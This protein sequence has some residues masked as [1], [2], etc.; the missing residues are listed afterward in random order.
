[1]TIF[2]RRNATWYTVKHWVQH[3]YSSYSDQ[4]FDTLTATEKETVDGVNYVLQNTEQVQGRVGALTNAKVRTDGIYRYV[5]PVSF[6]QKEIAEKDTV[7]EIFYK[8]PAV[9]TVIFYTNYTYIPRQQVKSEEN[10]DFSI[11]TSIPQRTGYKFGGWQYLKDS[12]VANA[13]GSYNDTDYIAVEELSDGSYSLQLSRTVVENAKL[14]D[15]GGT[16]ALY[17]Y[18]KWVSDTTQVRVILWTED[19]TGTDDVQAIAE[20]GNPEFYNQKYAG[21]SAEPVTHKPQHDTSDAYYSNAGSF[22][23]ENLISDSS[24]L[25]SDGTLL[26]GIKTRVDTEFK[27]RMGDV[28]GV[29][30]ADFYEL[31][32]FEIVH[33]EEDSITW[34]ATTASGDGKTTIY[35][36]FTRNIYTLKFHFYGEQGGSAYSVATKTNGYSYGNIE[37]FLNGEEFI[38]D[39]STSSSF[40]SNSFGKTTATNDS[41]M[42]V[43]KMITVKA[44]YGADLRDVWPGARPDEEINLSDGTLAKLA[45]WTA[46]MGKYRDDANNTASAHYHEATIMGVYASMGSEIVAAPANPETIHHLVAFWAARSDG[47]ISYYRYN[48]CYEVPDLNVDGMTKVSIY[49]NDTQNES[50]FLYLVP[51]DN[52]N[53]AKYSFNDLMRVSY[54]ASGTLTYNDENG[55]YYAVRGYND[56]YYALARQVIAPSTNS[57]GSQNPSARLHMTR[58]NP[59]ADHSTQYQD[60][61]GGWENRPWFSDRNNPYDLY[62]YYN[63]DHYTITYMASSNNSSTAAEVTLGTIELP[64]GAEVTKDTYGPKLNYTDKNTNSICPWTASTPEVPVCPDR[65]ENGTAEWTFKGWALGPA[66]VNMQ[67][68]YDEAGTA[69]GSDGFPISSN[70]R[71]YAI[72]ETPSY[73]VTFH[74]NGGNVDGNTADIEE[75]IPANTRY[76]VNGVIPRPHKENYVLK[77]WFNADENGDVT[78]PETAFDFDQ[79][80]AADKHVAAV[81]A[82]VTTERFSYTIWYVTQNP[83]EA[84]KNKPTETLGGVSYTV[85]DSDKHTDEMYTAN[86]VVN[87]TAVPQEGYVPEKVFD[88]FTPEASKSYDIIFAYNPVTSRSHTVRFIEAGTETGQTPRVIHYYEVTADRTVTTPDATE[89]AKVTGAG[90]RLVN[91][92]DGGSYTPVTDADALTWLDGTDLAAAKPNAKTTLV[93]DA[94][95][96][97]IV[98]LVQP[99]AYKISYANAAG[100]P[101]EAKSALDAV[102]AAAGTMA[103]SSGDKNPTLY[104]DGNKFTLKNPAS[105]IAN[106]KLYT[107]SHWMLAPGTTLADT[108]SK[109]TEFPT[110]DVTEGTKGDIGFIANWA[111]VNI[112]DL[113][114]TKH[115]EGNAGEP[116]REFSFT[117]TL[118][119]GNNQPVS[120]T[121]GNMTFNNG[122]ATFTL[123]H[124]QSL[125]A[126]GIPENYNYT[127][128]EAAADGYTTTVT[129]DVQGTFNANKS[130]TFT[131]TRALT[132]GT[133]SLVVSKAVAGDAGETTRYFHFTVELDDKTV[134]TTFGDFAFT[135]GV[136]NITLHHGESKTAIGL[137]NGVGYTVAEAEAN[138]DGYT[139]TSVNASG[140]IVGNEVTNVSFTNSRSVTPPAPGTGS[141]TISKTVTG[142]WGERS[143]SFLFKVTLYD[144]ADNAVAESVDGQFGQMAFTKGTA[145][146]TLKHGESITASG[147][148]AG[149]RY[150]VDERDDSGYITTAY[151]NTGTI[152]DSRTVTA[153]FVNYKGTQPR[154][155]DDASLALLLTLMGASL[156]V[157]TALPAAYVRKTKKRA[158]R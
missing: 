150:T 149:L 158:R 15:T 34:D 62:F 136:A 130:V 67:W 64:Y 27:N 39:A 20:G 68:T 98:Y 42:P 36:Y 49:G 25:N 37:D 44:K 94:I 120:G 73:T 138:T 119:D 51:I 155:G 19:L 102:T 93:G 61:Q 13:D 81:W 108:S 122:T 23:I 152:T 128:T 92:E 135:N 65:S 76:S 30:V 17:L 56:K 58:V 112:Y 121:Y 90:Y 110:L 88:T 53:I 48:H 148:P 125:T 137:P 117:V 33:E 97:E 103:G 16:L 40:G 74:L 14:V 126:T 3:D 8:I 47:G 115:V 100:S 79:N 63:R 12:A 80:I 107:F 52:N 24:L 127:V 99:I 140:S 69:Q 10:V 29:T 114:I 132:P 78:S 111:A 139:T 11:I 123:T 96:G 5:S 54:D 60:N 45:S 75:L 71:L 43:P 134:N 18:P 28:N 95:P 31:A 6:S 146:F 55:T 91:K 85:L 84:D 124:N 118:R 59:N 87:L 21:Y 86:M 106:D 26:D 133:G 101:A 116:D 156:F 32:A 157:L 57:I 66:G 104:A 113:T 83:F 4:P 70:L 72:W 143:R 41:Q 89:L 142:I 153:S 145:L 22:V 141:L 9:Y 151:G 154:T 147:L 50:N 2:Y 129:G 144:A 46:T 109:Q 38:F 82:P 77:G 131:N 1:M 7:V 35:V 105:F